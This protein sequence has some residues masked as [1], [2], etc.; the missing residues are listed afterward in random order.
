LGSVKSV[1]L[2]GRSRKESKRKMTIGSG[3]QLKERS[4]TK[5]R[6]WEERRKDLKDTIWHT[7][8]RGTWKIR[9]S[10]ANNTSYRKV[11]GRKKNHR[12][13]KDAPSQRL[14]AWS[15]RKEQPI[16][17]GKL[18][19]STRGERDTYPSGTEE[20]ISGK[21]HYVKDHRDP[22]KRSYLRNLN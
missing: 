1:L 4:T 13:A 12:R 22:H 21:I 6:G 16:L 5:Q 10:V 9:G 15:K 3:G 18:R 2:R 14:R 11:G 7:F 20:G 19:D 17:L 8:V